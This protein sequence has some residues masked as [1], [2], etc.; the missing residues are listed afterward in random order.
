MAQVAEWGVMGASLYT[1]GEELKKTAPQ[2]DSK[3]VNGMQRQMLESWFKQK[4][5][6][7]QKLN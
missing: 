6:D 3:W 5:M 1:E 7:E 2:K 4:M